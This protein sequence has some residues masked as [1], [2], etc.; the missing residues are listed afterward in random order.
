MSVP[1]GMVVRPNPHT[2]LGHNPGT[3]AL[4]CPDTSDP[5]SDAWDVGRLTDLGMNF[6]ETGK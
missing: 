6:N 2:L 3:E 4:C 1:A 5:D